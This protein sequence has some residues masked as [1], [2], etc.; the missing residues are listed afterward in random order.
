MLRMVVVEV[1][2]D[3]VSGR[4]AEEADGQVE[5]SREVTSK[6]LPQWLSPAFTAGDSRKM[7]DDLHHY[8]QPAYYDIYFIHFRSRITHG[9]HAEP[10]YR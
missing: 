9:E 7:A 6:S 8:I 3:I 1:A 10:P 2:E 4:G 5:R